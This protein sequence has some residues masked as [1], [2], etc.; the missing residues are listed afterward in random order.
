MLP[1][2]LFSMSNQMSSILLVFFGWHCTLTQWFNFFIPGPILIISSYLLCPNESSKSEIWTRAN[3]T[4]TSSSKENNE[5]KKNY[6]QHNYRNEGQWM[7]QFLQISVV[8]MQ[9]YIRFYMYCRNWVMRE[10]Q[11]SRLF[12]SS[13]ILCFMEQREQSPLLFFK[14]MNILGKVLQRKS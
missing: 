11:K 3:S 7:T 4:L 6:Q 1:S 5:L 9:Q 8:F 14:A 13:F 12:K 2:V 10:V